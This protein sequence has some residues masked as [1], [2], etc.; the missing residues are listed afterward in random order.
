MTENVHSSR[1]RETASVF[2][3]GRTC[4]RSSS[5]GRGPDPPPPCWCGC[6][7]SAVLLGVKRGLTVALK[8][9]PL[10]TSCMEHLLC[11]S[12]HWC[13]FGEMSAQVFCSFF[14]WVTHVLFCIRK[15][16]FCIL[17]QVPCRICNLQLSTSAAR[18]QSC[19]CLLKHSIFNLMDSNL[20]FF[21]FIT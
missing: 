10:V 11:A 13:I 4:L 1:V 8:C 5:T 15:H 21:S 14:N 20:S 17:T 9:S 16:S 2:Q 12:R 3:S 19:W 6:L 7:L 18:F